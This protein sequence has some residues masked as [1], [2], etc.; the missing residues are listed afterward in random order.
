MVHIIRLQACHD[1]YCAFSICLNIAGITPIA[2]IPMPEYTKTFDSTTR[3][4]SVSAG[5]L[6][7]TGWCTPTINIVVF[8]IYHIGHC[9][10][11]R[12]HLVSGKGFT[13]I[14][15][16]TTQMQISSRRGGQ[17][18][19]DYSLGRNVDEGWHGGDAMRIRDILIVTKGT[20]SVL[21]ERIVTTLTSRPCNASLLEDRLQMFWQKLER[22]WAGQSA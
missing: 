2:R 3:S 12:R 4:K 15:I 17:G 21:S 16:G 14:R 19:S 6:A 5:F 18:R 1:W 22:L 9:R 11:F 20:V 8:I 10:T 13:C 7:R